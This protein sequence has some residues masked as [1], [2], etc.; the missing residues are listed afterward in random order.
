MKV[1]IYSL[2]L[3][4]L[5]CN[6]ENNDTSEINYDL[7]GTWTIEQLYS[8]DYWGGSPYWKNS[9]FLKQLKFTDDQKY[10]VKLTNDFELIG[11]Y[12]VLS[13]NM[14]EITWDKPK[15]PQYPTFTKPYKVESNG[16]LILSTGF[17]S[18]IISE[19]YR[20]ID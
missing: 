7:R 18:T 15:Y 10:Y 20:R 2:G 13:E 9:D 17:T 19:K 1:Y 5:V 11:T 8:D 3:L 14:L 4:F 12:K 16:R 6:C